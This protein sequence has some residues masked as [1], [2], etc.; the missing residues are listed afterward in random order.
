MC[1]SDLQAVPELV[2]IG[3]RHIRDMNS[4]LHN[5]H[6]YVRGKERCT[7]LVCPEDLARYG[8]QD[9]DEA[10]ISTDTGSAV[11]AVQASEDMMPGVISIPHGFGH[12]YSD[13]RQSIAAESA[14]G[15]SV[16]DLIDDSLDMPSGTSVVNGVPVR[17]CVAN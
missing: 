14:P 1:S 8:L 16:N 6:Q 4:W 3:R 7:A 2:M 12:R 9:G 17:L 11:L 10:R 5:I 15:V 13:T